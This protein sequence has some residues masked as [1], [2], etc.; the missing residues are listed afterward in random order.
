MTTTLP[1]RA[2]VERAEPLDMNASRKPARQ[3]LTITIK[4]RVDGFDTEVCY[5]GSIEQLLAVTKRLRE[6]GA[7]PVS[8]VQPA[9]AATTNGKSKSETV[10]PEYKPDGTPCC[11]VHHGALA[12]GQYGWYCRSKAKP[13]DVQNAKGYCALKFAD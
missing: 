12:E 5:T 4:A 6:L 8:A 1:S 3:D 11:P 7:E 13:G 9:Q 2:D 10:Q